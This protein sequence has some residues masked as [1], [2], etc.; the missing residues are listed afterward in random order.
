MTEPSSHAVFD[1]ASRLSKA[2]KIERLVR[3]CGQA[4]IGGRM[5]E[6]GAGSGFIS[7]YFGTRFK[8]VLRVDAVDVADQRVA[9]EGFDFRAYDG[10]QLPFA[11]GV[12]DLIVSNHVIEHVGS[13][14]QQE[15]HLREMARVLSPGGLI[16]LAAPSKWQL[17]EPHFGLAGLSW[18]PRFM[19][20]S[21]V[22]L[23]GKG[24]RYDCDP[25]GHRDLERM[26]GRA[27]L[28][29]RNINAPAFLALCEESGGVAGR[30]LRRIPLPLL[31]AAY[32]FSPTMV[33]LLLRDTDRP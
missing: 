30:W 25:M 14:E 32:R 10:H 5:L 31:E 18:I 11:D 22:R 2:A 28:R 24:D 3:E 26:A 29:A 20:D 27:G 15:V 9:S 7:E 17:V 8:G 12:F 4:S 13:R 1:A 6:V 21:Y 23:A 33:F 16:Y 19:R